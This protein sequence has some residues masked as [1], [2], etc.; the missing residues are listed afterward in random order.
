M[1]IVS[2]ITPAFN[3]KDFFRST[4]ASVVA[5]KFSDFE[6]IVIDDCSTDGSFEVLSELAKNEQRIRLFRQESNQGVAAARNRGLRLAN[7]RYITFLDADDQI[8]PDYLEKQLDFMKGHGPL[9]SSSYRR[10][11]PNSSSDFIVPEETTY[12]SA[13]NGNPLSCLTTMYDKAVVGDVFFPEDL[14]KAEDYVFWL[15]ILRRGI[16]AKGNKEVLATYVI[17]SGS[18]SRSKI[19]LIRW[20]FFIYHRTQGLSW[21]SSLFHVFRWSIYGF[22]KYRGVR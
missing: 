19:K 12:A 22:R 13:L 3:C 20:M 8:D 9:I 2:I 5:Q 21:L 15:N 16:V 7:G 14:E 11:A 6:W 18:R 17:H 1:P 4:F 10:L